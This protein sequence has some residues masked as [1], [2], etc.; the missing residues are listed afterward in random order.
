MTV[1]FDV[2]RCCDPSDVG[3]LAERDSQ[4]VKIVQGLSGQSSLVCC[5]RIG[6]LGIHYCEVRQ[7]NAACCVLLHLQRKVKRREHTFCDGQ[8]ALRRCDGRRAG[9]R[10]SCWSRL[11]PRAGSS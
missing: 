4:T 11:W 10:K 9:E 8:A 2:R 7:I 1:N 6:P 5:S 3:K